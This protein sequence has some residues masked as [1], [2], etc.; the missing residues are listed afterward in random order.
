MRNIFLSIIATL[1]FSVS[2]IAQHKQ[3]EMKVEGLSCPI[4]SYGLEKKLKQI[5]GIGNIN[6]ELT[7][8]IVTFTMKEGK[9]ITEE[10]VKKK[11]KDAGYTFKYLKEITTENMK[12]NE[13][14]E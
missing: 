9:I 4:C 1:F 14:K 10:Q 7:T 8:G 3:Y 2:A 12:E 5:D 6:I 13:N 11:V